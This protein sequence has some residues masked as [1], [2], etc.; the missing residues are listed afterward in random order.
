[1]YQIEYS[2]QSL[3]VLRRMPANLSLL[4]RKKIETVTQDPVGAQGVK[5]LSGRDGYRLRVGD[6]RVLYL[7]DGQRLRV[8]VTEIGQRG[9]IY[10]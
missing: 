6:W 3:R 5:K 8:L 10:Q 1:M 4:I 9:G 2:M 7:L